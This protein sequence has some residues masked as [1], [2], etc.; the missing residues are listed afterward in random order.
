[1]QVA[2]PLE[3]Q[4]QAPKLVFPGEHA[5]DGAKALLENGRLEQRLAASLRRLA[6]ARIRVDVRHHPAIEDRLAVVRTIVRAV[7]AHNAAAQVQSARAMRVSF[8]NAS[9][10]NGDG[11]VTLPGRS[12]K[13]GR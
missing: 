6:P 4:Q 11:I 9:R 3:A 2:Q 1:M 5:L 10:N 7:Q 12:R 13:I 8:G